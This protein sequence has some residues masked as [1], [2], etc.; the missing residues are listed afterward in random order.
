MSINTQNAPTFDIHSPPRFPAITPLVY[1]PVFSPHVTPV[2]C[3]HTPLERAAAPHYKQQLATIP[4]I[5]TSK[6][7]TSSSQVT[8]VD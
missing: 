2:Q 6:L 4:Q 3:I 8:A 7:Q 5:P 1:L